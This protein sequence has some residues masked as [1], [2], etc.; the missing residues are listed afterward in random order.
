MRLL[1][2]LLL[3]ACVGP[4]ATDDSAPVDHDKVSDKDGAIN[5]GI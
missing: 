4:K 2:L 5:A 1:P 3:A